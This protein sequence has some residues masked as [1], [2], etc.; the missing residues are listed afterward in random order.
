MQIEAQKERLPIS[1]PSAGQPVETQTLLRLTR[2]VDVATLG[3]AV[4]A[5]TG[6][7]MHMTPCHTLS[8]ASCFVGELMFDWVVASIGSLPNSVRASGYHTVAPMWLVEQSV[9]RD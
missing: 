6:A 3:D 1:G 7:R 5:G 8:C 9:H 4:S 2:S